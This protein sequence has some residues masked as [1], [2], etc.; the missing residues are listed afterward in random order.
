MNKKRI[1]IVRDRPAAGGGICNYYNAIGKHLTSNVHYSDIGQAHSYYEKPRLFTRLVSNSRFL[2]LA[3]D[4]LSLAAKIVWIRPHIVHLNPGMDFKTRRSLRRDA[5]NLLIA[6]AFCRKTLVF[7]RGWDNDAC[8]KPHFPTG[9]N[10]WLHRVYKRA[11]YH[12][13]L[14]SRF[15]EDL[16]RWGFS[17]SI[18]LETTVASDE[19]LC[20]TPPKKKADDRIRLLF[21]SRIEIAKGVYELVE[22]YRCLKKNDP[23]FTLTIAGDGPEL[24][25]LK[26]YCSESKLHDIDFTGYVSG[27]KKT[28]IYQNADLFCFFSYTEG[29]P[30]AVLEAMAM[31]LPIV[32][33]EAGGLRDILEDNTTGIVLKKDEEA[34]DKQR[35]PPELIANRILDLTKRENMLERISQ[36][37]RSYAKERFAADRVASR[38]EKIYDELLKAD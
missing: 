24:A 37:N 18:S 25:P 6:K 5:V 14:S 15:K 30:N 27:E 9:D 35:F 3:L 20:G 4:C 32:S 21:L 36:H 26:E 29:M 33:S 12:I 19:V 16:L 8:G 1:I 34:D 22:A 7:W 23:R 38:I 31:G 2:R 17:E 10:S 11:D 13:V 28:S